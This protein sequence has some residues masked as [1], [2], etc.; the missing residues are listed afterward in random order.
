MLDNFIAHITNPYNDPSTDD[1]KALY[2]HV[3]TTNS[4]A[5]AFYEH[6][7]FRAHLF[8]PYYYAI[9]GRRRDGFTYVLYINGGHPP[10][11][12]VDYVG[13]CLQSTIYGIVTLQPVRRWLNLPVFLTRS[14][15]RKL[16]GGVLEVA[17]RGGGNQRLATGG[18][19]G[20]GAGYAIN[21]ANG[22]QGVWPRI[23]QIASSSTAA[24]FTS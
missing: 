12:L 7:G 1:V 4:Q 11:S 23:R 16:A 22:G 21:G 15:F 13:H 20:T 17:G 3:L 2:L 19:G 10:W 14:L 24:V 8:L 5:I 9:K 18:G 6:R